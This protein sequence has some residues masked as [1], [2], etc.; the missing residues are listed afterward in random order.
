[1]DFA[2][3]IHKGCRVKL[4]FLFFASANA[5]LPDDMQEAFSNHIQSTNI[6]KGQN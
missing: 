5:Y 1:M 6:R 2:L 4:A 3:S